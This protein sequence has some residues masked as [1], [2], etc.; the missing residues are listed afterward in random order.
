MGVNVRALKQ[1]WRGA[2]DTRNCSELSTSEDYKRLTANYRFRDAENHP[3]IVYADFIVKNTWRDQSGVHGETWVVV[4][5]ES[6]TGERYSITLDTW[7]FPY[8]YEF[9]VGQRYTLFIELR[10]TSGIRGG[11]RY[12]VQQSESEEFNSRG[13]Q[14]PLDYPAADWY[15][16]GDWYGH[17]W[18]RVEP[19]GE[20]TI[21]NVYFVLQSQTWGEAF[22]A[23]EGH[24]IGETQWPGSSPEWEGYTFADW[25][26]NPNLEGEPY[27]KDTPIYKDTRLYARWNYTGSGGVWPRAHRGAIGGIRDG[28]TL[29]AGQT[30]PL[31]ASGYNMGLESPREQR[32]RWYPVTWRLSDGASGN[33]SDEAPFQAELTIGDK[34]DGRLYITYVEEVYD[35]TYWQETGQVR[36]VEERA[37]RV[38]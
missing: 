20:G 28:D 18:R 17:R 16:A 3:D 5:M 2:I 38:D 37:F 24:G 22:A 19:E 13:E 4:D 8:P 23:L 26:D 34:G 30:L 27:T 11:I 36:E 6:M 1:L 32:F 35:G 31:T 29:S 33:F 9:G 14:H 7:V 15:D 25:Y 12:A 10:Y 21:Y